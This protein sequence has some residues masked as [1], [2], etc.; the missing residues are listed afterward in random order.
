MH[1]RRFLAASA[2]EVAPRTTIGC[3]SRITG[4]TASGAAAMGAPA[5]HDARHD[6][7]TRLGGGAP[8]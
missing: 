3:A 8:P 6:A 2:G 7:I 4:G 5:L 1:R